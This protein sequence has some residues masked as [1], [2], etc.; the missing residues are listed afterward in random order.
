MNG[1][2]AQDVG[3]VPPPSEPYAR[4]VAIVEAG[5]LKQGLR[6]ALGAHLGPVIDSFVDNI[7]ASSPA[8]QQEYFNW[9]QDELI[10]GNTRRLRRLVAS[11][12]VWSVPIVT[13]GSLTAPEQT[14]LRNGLQGVYRSDPFIVGAVPSLNASQFQALFDGT[15]A[16]Y[17]L[18]EIEKKQE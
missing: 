15:A 5:R 13:D 3:R 6:N 16:T 2:Q 7:P 14:A 4:S 12:T 17:R 10:D 18:P 8:G 1:Y 11:E 9:L